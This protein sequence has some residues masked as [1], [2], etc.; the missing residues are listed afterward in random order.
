MSSSGQETSKRDERSTSKMQEAT[1]Q[2]AEIVGQLID[3]LTGKETSITY[4]FDNLTIDV[5]RAQGPNGQNLGSAQWTING[6]VVITAETHR[7]SADEE[8]RGG[9]QESLAASSTT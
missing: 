5:P 2:W 6:K 3:R 9:P 7:V 4:T 8:E 1:S